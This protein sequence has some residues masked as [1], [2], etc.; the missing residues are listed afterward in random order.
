[1]ADPRD[2][3]PAGGRS[4][5]GATDGGRRDNR[6]GRDA[7]NLAGAGAQRAG[8]HSNVVELERQVG[9][10]ALSQIEGAGGLAMMR[11]LSWQN[12]LARLGYT[13][14]LMVLHDLGCL[15]VGLGTPSP[16]PR[17]IAEPELCE[18]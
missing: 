9:S 3:S 7:R 1:M 14:P 17:G 10:L 8:N 15:I 6:D 18:V 4:P 12:I 13:V 5:G 16:V 2:R 11:A